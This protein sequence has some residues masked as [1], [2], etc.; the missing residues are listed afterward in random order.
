MNSDRGTIDFSIG[1]DFVAVDLVFM[2]KQAQGQNRGTDAMGAIMKL[3]ADRNLPVEF[4]AYRDVDSDMYNGYYTWA[5][6]GFD[7]LA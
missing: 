1:N 4:L 6:M 5:K 7:G 2:Y 3:A